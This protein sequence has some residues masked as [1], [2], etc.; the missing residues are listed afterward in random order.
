MEK[1]CQSG[2]EKACIYIKDN[3]KWYD[4][5]WLLPLIT[6]LP[7]EH[8]KKI[9]ALSDCFSIG[10]VLSILSLSTVAIRLTLWTKSST[11][12]PYWIFNVAKP[13][14]T[15][16][17]KILIRKSEFWYRKELFYTLATKFIVVKYT[18]RAKNWKVGKWM[19][20]KGQ[21]SGIA[22][23]AWGHRMCRL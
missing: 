21:H 3:C 14:K 17:L 4:D 22:H 13:G 11:P 6:P 1:A 2:H 12:Y 7:E 15:I 23:V 8:K 18:K 10:R 20:G 9:L 16:I 5:Y 19:L